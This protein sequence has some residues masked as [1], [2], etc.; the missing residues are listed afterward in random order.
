M[1][2]KGVVFLYKERKKME[3][4]ELKVELK[5]APWYRKA[6]RDIAEE[7]ANDNSISVEKAGELFEKIGTKIINHAIDVK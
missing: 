2:N 1:P 4:K 5:L 3:A 7:L 6:M